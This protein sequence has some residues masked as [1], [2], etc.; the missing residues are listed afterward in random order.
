MNPTKITTGQNRLEERAMQLGWNV[1]AFLERLPPTI[2]TGEDIRHLLEAAWGVGTNYII[3]NEA[4]TK[5]DFIRDIR[6]CLEDCKLADFWL[7][8]IE[9]PEDLAEEKTKLIQE[10]KALMQIFIAILR[11]LGQKSA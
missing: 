7:R 2:R 10:A 6:N 3:A 11:R 9:E 5:R 1:K 8:L 4:S